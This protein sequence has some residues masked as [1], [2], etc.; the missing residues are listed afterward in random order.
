[1]RKEKKNRPNPHLSL[2]F[3]QNLTQRN[4]DKRKKEQQKRR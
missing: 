2:Y 1:M 3:R 4:D